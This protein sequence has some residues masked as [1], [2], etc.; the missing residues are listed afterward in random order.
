MFVNIATPIGFTIQIRG[1]QGYVTTSYFGGAFSDPNSVLRSNHPR[2]G[3][4][5]ET[6][7]N[8]AAIIGRSVP[9]SLHPLQGRMANMHDQG[10]E[11]LGGVRQVSLQGVTLNLIL[12]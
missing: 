10:R 3:P 4:N 1:G 12:N 9:N 2:G 11:E 5:T 7:P 6:V 8:A